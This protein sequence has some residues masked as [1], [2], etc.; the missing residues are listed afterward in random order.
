[1]RASIARLIGS[2]PPFD[3]LEREHL[4][5]TQ[6]WIDTGAPLFRIAKPD[7]PPQHLVSYFVVLDRIREQILLVDHRSAHLW[8]PGGG[9][10][11]VDEDP[12]QTVCR[13]LAEELGL[14]AEFTWPEPL[15]LTV[16]RT[17]GSDPGHTD[18]SLWYVLTGDCRHVP[19]FDDREFHAIRW[20]G[21]CD[22]PWDRV[23]PHMQRFMAKLR[24][25]LDLERA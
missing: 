2:I 21:F 11:E 23:D 3:E 15:F 1:M 20:F 22:L 18:V 13:E 10:V 14:E 16:T 4:L 19:S 9:H 17:V 5:A 8:L 7:R 25:R 12:R 6:L 24:A